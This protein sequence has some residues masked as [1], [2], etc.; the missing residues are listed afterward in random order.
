MRPQKLTKIQSNQFKNQLDIIY[1]T[2]HNSKRQLNNSFCKDNLFLLMCNC[3][4]WKFHPSNLLPIDY[5]SDVS[6]TSYT[7]FTSWKI[8]LVIMQNCSFDYSEPFLRM[9]WSCPLILL[10]YR[11][12]NVNT[13]RALKW[14]I[15]SVPLPLFHRSKPTCWALV[16]CI[17][18]NSLPRVVTEGGC[19]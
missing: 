12:L 5:S 11:A 15:K 18:A 2:H 14:C 9:Y 16:I 3:F 4:S 8:A 10:K 1:R 13:A 17:N 6:S 7:F 19:C